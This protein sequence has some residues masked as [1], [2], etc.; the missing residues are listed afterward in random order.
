MMKKG[1]SEITIASYFLIFVSDK[2][3]KRGAY[4]THLKILISTKILKTRYSSCNF[5]RSSNLNK[6]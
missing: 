3:K 6:F 2:H 1:R 5:K 4:K